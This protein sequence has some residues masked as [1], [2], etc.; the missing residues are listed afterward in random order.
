MMEDGHLDL[1]HHCN[2]ILQLL[3]TR[4]IKYRLVP[5]RSGKPTKQYLLGLHWLAQHDIDEGGLLPK[6]TCHSKRVVLDVNMCH[7]RNIISRAC[8]QHLQRQST[9]SQGPEFLYVYCVRSFSVSEPDK[10]IAGV[11]ELTTGSLM[12]LSASS[13]I[14]RLSCVT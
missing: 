7:I 14:S 9:I 3:S 13:N 12:S 5:S 2:N 11:L 1:G 4:R 8:L 6:F 10:G